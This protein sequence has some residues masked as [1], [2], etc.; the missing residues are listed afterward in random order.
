M[1]EVK[2]FLKNLTD[3]AG[4]TSDVFKRN[5]LKE[6][7]QILVLDFIYS[8]PKY[9]ELCFYGGS[10]LKHCFDLPRLSEYLDFVD[11]KSSI[12]LELLASDLEKYF[13]KNTD[14]D[15]IVSI[16]KFRIYLKFPILRELKLAKTGESDRLFLKVEIFSGFDFCR[17]HKMEF[18]PLFKFNKSILIKIFDLPTLMSTKIRAVLYRKW[19]KKDKDGDISIKVKGRDYFDLMWYL[20]KGIKPNFKCLD[21]IKNNEELKEKLLAIVK[22][23][24][25]KSIE[26][27]L[28][29]L[30]ADRNFV[31]NLSK[32][33]KDILIRGIKDKL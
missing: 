12:K 16:Q 30:I 7:L 21:G 14:L 20:E 5:I 22:K 1:E 3:N 31:K 9:S 27:D 10:A 23:V 4:S 33:M 24:D 18:I 26:L 17:N 8:H 19:E 25:V 2:V 32:N 13:K 28:E 11:L 6:Y 29:A 15:I